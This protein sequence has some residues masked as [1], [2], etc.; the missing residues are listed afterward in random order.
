[1]PGFCAALCIFLQRNGVR[2]GRWCGWANHGPKFSRGILPAKQA[3][4]GTALSADF[5]MR[6]EVTGT[7]ISSPGFA[8]YACLSPFPSC[9]PPTKPGSL[10]HF[11]SPPSFIVVPSS[12]RPPSA[13][14]SLFCL[15]DSITLLICSRPQVLNSSGPLIPC[16]AI[17]RLSRLGHHTFISYLVLASLHSPSSGTRS[18]LS[19][20]LV[21]EPRQSLLP[22]KSSRAIV[23]AKH[24]SRVA[25]EQARDPPLYSSL[26]NIFPVVRLDRLL[27]FFTPSTT[28][29]GF[30]NLRSP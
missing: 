10:H 12:E 3:C 11:P 13:R 26:F 15:R 14:T 2:S 7:G 22:S 20:Q 19:P 5:P 1:M 17:S 23:E 16:R 18:H 9:P 24:K 4:P 27:R 25:T 29:L 28:R 30:D 8:Q 21:C 6:V